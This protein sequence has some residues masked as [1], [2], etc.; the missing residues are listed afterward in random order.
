MRLPKKAKHD[1]AYFL[2][3]KLI[4]L[5]SAMPHRL[6]RFLGAFMGLV[7]WRLSRRDRHRMSRHLTLVYGS[8][9]SEA[10]KH[11]IGRDF[12]VNS[13]K[14]LVDVI[15]L[16]EHYRDEIKP[17]IKVDG[18]EHIDRAYKKG[19]GV[20]GITGHIGN[21][22]LLA[23]FLAELGYPVAVIGREMYDPRMDRFLVENREALGLANIA[24]T[25]SPRR[26]V[27]WLKDGG[28]VG[29]L[30]DIDS[31]RVRG[32]FMP[33]FG[34]LAQTPVGQ[35]VLSLRT[36]AA[37]V[38]GACLRNADNTYRITFKPEVTIQPS[39]DF[40]RDVYDLTL[41]CSRVL[42][43]IIHENKSQWIWIHNRWCARPQ[44]T[45]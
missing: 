27:E 30:I 12:F 40:D 29:I 7:A 28:I 3:P 44:E 31:S 18:V 26:L 19:H 45:A 41:K 5:I 39:G 42:E 43:S 2:A 4:A 20:I 17:L 6:A 37:L 14:N 11:N 34:R 15:R 8:S 35:S 9:L 23:V 25:D 33:V 36:G 1:V 21:F 10:D 22:E 24:T 13:G 38:P 16:K 32:M